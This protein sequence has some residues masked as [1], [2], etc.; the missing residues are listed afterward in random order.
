MK[1]FVIRCFRFTKMSVVVKRVRQLSDYAC[2]G[3]LK[4]VK[5]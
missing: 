3:L 1:G 2:K 5:R 4:D